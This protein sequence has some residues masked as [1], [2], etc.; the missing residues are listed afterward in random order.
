MNGKELKKRIKNSGLKLAVIIEKSGI[1]ERT[2]YNLYDKNEVEEHF[3]KSLE[4]AGIN[5]LNTAEVPQPSLEVLHD[6][7]RLL[8]DTIKL[9]SDDNTYIKDTSK[10]FKAIVDNAVAD[11]TLKISKKPAKV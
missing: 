6:T 11:G 7:I 4:K 2:L 5:L 8:H 1:P 9:L 10:T 3:L